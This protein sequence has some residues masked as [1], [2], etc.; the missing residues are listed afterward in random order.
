MI[1]KKYIALTLLFITPNIFALIGVY[2]PSL[3]KKTYAQLNILTNK[4]LSTNN[5]QSS[6]VN[7]INKSLSENLITESDVVVNKDMTVTILSK[8]GQ[9]FVSTL[10]EK[11][12]YNVNDIRYD[13]SPLDVL[14]K[15]D[16]IGGS[17]LVR[18]AIDSKKYEM[19]LD[20]NNFRLNYAKQNG[21]VIYCFSKEYR[22]VRYEDDIYN[23]RKYLLFAIKESNIDT[24]IEQDSHF[25]LKSRIP[26]TITYYDA[27]GSKKLIE[28]IYSVYKNMEIIKLN[29]LAEDNR[30]R[31]IESQIKNK[32][33][34]ELIKQ[35][36]LAKFGENL[37]IGELT[38]CGTVI[39]LRAKMAYVQTASDAGSIWILK[40]LLYPQIIDG[41]IVGCKDGNRWYKRYGNWVSDNGRGFYKSSNQFS[42]IDY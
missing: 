36:N 42:Y 5:S 22:Q 10:V 24:V 12:C 21:S 11:L 34:Q 15:D 35:Q 25:Y 41:K 4:Y 28:Q 8:R 29:S 20:Y 14:A 38:N 16:F 17:G 27:N 40:S 19:W 37:S 3:D 6:Y 31:Y 7:I 1:L 33:N 30:K 32:E 18:P 26:S 23:D 39:E 9:E 13:Y 2:P